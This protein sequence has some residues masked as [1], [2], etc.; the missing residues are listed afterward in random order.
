MRQGDG[1]R[2]ARAGGRYVGS[3]RVSS[4]DAATALATVPL[5]TV[6]AGTVGTASVR[7]RTHRDGHNGSDDDEHEQ[8]REPDHGEPP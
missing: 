5:L 3:V 7:T 1:Y 6:A 4:N 8:R 2:R